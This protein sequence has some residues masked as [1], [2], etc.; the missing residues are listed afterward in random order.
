MKT[1]LLSIIILNIGMI[2]TAIHSSYLKLDVVTEYLII[3]LLIILSLIYI[4]TI[5]TGK[6]QN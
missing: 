5:Q 3:G 2:I 1:I 4:K 6:N